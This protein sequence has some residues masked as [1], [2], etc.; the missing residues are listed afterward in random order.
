MT[1]WVDDLRD[2]GWRLGPSC[3]MTADT[4]EELHDF[5]R[6]IGMRRS[7]FQ[8]KPRLWHYDLTASRRAAAIRLGAVELDIRESMA[9]IRQREAA[10]ET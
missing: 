4:R 10:V 6:R 3:H 9:R 7:W 2:Y 5:A 8:D 1:V